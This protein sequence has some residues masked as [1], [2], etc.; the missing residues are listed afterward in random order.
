MTDTPAGTPAPTTRAT[1]KGARKRGE[2]LDAAEHVLL[3]SGYADLSMRAVATAA[4]VRLG[5]L[6]YYFPA[7]SDLVA[8][9]LDRVL[10]RSLDRLEPLLA[11]AADPAGADPSAWVAALLED[12]ED[13]ALVRLFTELWALAALDETVAVAVRAFYTAYRDQVAAHLG[14]RRPD[15]PADECRARAEVFVMLVEGASLFRSGVAAHRSA[16]TDATLIATAAALL[17]AR[18]R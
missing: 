3:A 6:Q 5:H 1:G 14:G 15:L 13:P 4:G 11:T 18:D 2:L 7:R 9:V 17:T 10:R 12:Q 16:R 8:A